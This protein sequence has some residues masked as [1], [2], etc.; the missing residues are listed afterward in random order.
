GIE[1][2]GDTEQIIPTRV[3][4][5]AGMVATENKTYFQNF[6]LLEY[7]PGKEQLLSVI[8]SGRDH[9]RSADFNFRTDFNVTPGTVG[10]SGRAPLVFAGYGYKDEKG[11]YDDLEQLDLQGK[12]AVILSGFPGQQVP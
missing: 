10:K 2:M 11:S 7:S 9:E 6:S 4:S 1:P 5:M 8:T 12:V 3:Q